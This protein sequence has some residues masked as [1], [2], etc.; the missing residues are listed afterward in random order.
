MQPAK[1]VFA[2][3]WLQLVRSILLMMSECSNLEEDLKALLCKILFL[4]WLYM[5]HCAATYCCCNAAYCR[6]AGAAARL[7]TADGAVCP[8]L[9]SLSHGGKGVLES[10]E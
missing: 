2:Q 3:R 4:T 6:S 1:G 9:S 8:I 5:A 10:L 7:E